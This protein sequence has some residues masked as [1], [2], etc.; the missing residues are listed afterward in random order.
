M[1]FKRFINTIFKDPSGISLGLDIGSHAI[2]AVQLKRS[3][4]RIRLISYDIL[5]L[6]DSEKDFFQT[7]LQKIIRKILE[8]KNFQNLRLV[9]S[10]GGSQVIVRQ[11]RFPLISS[12]ELESSLRWEVRDH[13]PFPIDEV[14]L[15]FQII[16]RNKGSMT[17]E[18]LLVAITKKA[19]EKHLKM[20]KQLEMQPSIIDVNPLALMNCLWWGGNH[21]VD[22]AIILMDIGARVTTISIFRKELFYFTRDIMLAGNDFTGELQKKLGLNFAQAEKQKKENESDP[23][24]FESTL[25]RLVSELQQS[26]LYFEKKTGA[27]QFEK[28]YLSGG[29]ARMKGLDEFLTRGLSIPAIVAMPFKNILLEGRNVSDERLDMLSPQLT[30]ALG[31][32][33]RE[34]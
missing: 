31:L 18:V 5:E 27:M 34:E 13:I 20:L 2:K 22:K 14:E 33:L 4:E 16:S 19:L 25:E 12:K 24:L 7:N 29:G 9:T 8:G 3:Q 15:K 1:L 10:L 26:L 11:V 21:K 32:A 23:K 6:P 17:M 30:L 28:I